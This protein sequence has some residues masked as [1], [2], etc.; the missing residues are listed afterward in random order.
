MLAPFRCVT[1]ATRTRPGVIHIGICS[2][3]GIRRRPGG[4]VTRAAYQDHLRARDGAAGKNCC[5]SFLE[6]KLHLAIVVDEYGGTVGLV[7]LENIVEELVGQI[8]DGSIR[9]NP[10]L[11]RSE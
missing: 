11:T 7:T 1:K 2:R 4:L 9:R 5:S 8:R 6:R 3:C 10:L